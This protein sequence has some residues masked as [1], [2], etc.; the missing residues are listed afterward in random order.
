M[1]LQRQVCRIVVQN[2]SHTIDVE[3]VYYALTSII[4]NMYNSELARVY[5]CDSI[6]FHHSKCVYYCMS[7]CVHCVLQATK[8]SHAAIILWDTV[9]WQQVG[10]L[11]SHALTVTRLEFSHNGRYLLS[12]SRDRSWTI[13][14]SATSQGK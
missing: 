13:W 5:S 7:S 1:L 3:V 12:V 11:Q 9:T 4:L 6:D 14:E 2:L 8:A 10:A